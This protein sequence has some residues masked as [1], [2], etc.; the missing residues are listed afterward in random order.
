VLIGLV[1]V[2]LGQ[3]RNGEVVVGATAFA[4]AAARLLLPEPRVGLL[5]V[6]RRWFDVTV[7]FLAGVTILVVAVEVPG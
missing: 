3:F 4:A 6:R 7:L 5:A 1:V 2:A